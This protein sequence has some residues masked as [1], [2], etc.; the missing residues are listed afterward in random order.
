MQRRFGHNVVKARKGQ[1]PE[2]LARGSVAERSFSDVLMPSHFV[3]ANHNTTPA[4][5]AGSLSKDA[6]DSMSYG[7]ITS[8][9]INGSMEPEISESAEICQIHSGFHSGFE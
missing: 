6:A 1:F 9:P 5:S 4:A 3:C 8:F 7:V 2:L